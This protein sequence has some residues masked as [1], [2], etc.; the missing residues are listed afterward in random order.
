MLP[1]PNVESCEIVTKPT[2]TLLVGAY[3][4]PSTLEPLPDLEASLKF[5]KDPIVI[6][7]LKIALD[8]ARILWSQQV[9]DLLAY[10]GLINLVQHF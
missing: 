9:P 5:F 8:E 1:M 2:R 10:Y 4:P 7:D 6:G 3:L